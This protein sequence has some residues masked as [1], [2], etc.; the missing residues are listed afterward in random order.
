MAQERDGKGRFRKGWSG[1]P[2]AS[3]H[4]ANKRR[5]A[6]EQALTRRISP[7]QADAFVDL[8]YAQAMQDRDPVAI[9]VLTPYILGRPTEPISAREAYAPERIPRAEPMDIDAIAIHAQQLLEA[10]E[11]GRGSESETKMVRELLETLLRTRQL[12]DV[13]TQMASIQTLLEALKEAQGA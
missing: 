10:Y 11:A 1:G 6:L 7:D 5:A 9:K 13:Q 8:L 2:G 3:A 12:T 4:K